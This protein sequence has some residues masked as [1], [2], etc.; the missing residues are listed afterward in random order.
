MKVNVNREK[1]LLIV[2]L[3]VTMVVSMLLA[4][5]VTTQVKRY[6]V[7]QNL[8]ATYMNLTMDTNM[9]KDIR[10]LLKEEELPAVIGGYVRYLT[11]GLRSGIFVW[12]APYAY[13]NLDTSAFL[14]EGRTFTEEE[15]VQ[16]KN[17]ALASTEQLDVQLGEDIVI[18]GISY[19]VIGLFASIPQIRENDIDTIIPVRSGVY[20][21]KNS[22]IANITFDQVLNEQQKTILADYVGGY[23]NPS[24]GERVKS[25]RDGYYL[26]YTLLIV[27]LMAVCV[28][29]VIMLFR[30]L[31]AQNL[32]KYVIM[33]ASGA[34]NFTVFR[35]IFL[36]SFAYVVGCFVLA[37]GLYPLTQGVR[38]WFFIEESIHITG[39]VWLLLGYIVVVSTFLIPFARKVARRPIVDRSL[40]R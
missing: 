28:I 2:T 8:L 16:G 26:D 25:Y 39:A 21:V 15:I 1:I 4:T 14:T 3:T 12:E 5:I 11:Q 17:V 32:K 22:V 18:E 33:K 9:E 31:T 40:W 35:R 34:T 27:I 23:L 20:D 7:T 29:N 30:Y 10:Q 24:E 6:E 38:K 13:L 36:T 19:Q 37:G